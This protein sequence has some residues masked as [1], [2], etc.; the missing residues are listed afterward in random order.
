MHMFKK[1]LGDPFEL[2][3]KRDKIH[4]AEWQGRVE[5]GGDRQLDT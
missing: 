4:E 5:G 2:V 3:V 1:Q